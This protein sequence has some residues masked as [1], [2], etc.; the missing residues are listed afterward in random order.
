MSGTKEIHILK[1][2][3]IIPGS[4]NGKDFVNTFFV[5]VILTDLVDCFAIIYLNFYYK[6]NLS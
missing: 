1:R 6:Y 2:I 4:I 5:G 3:N